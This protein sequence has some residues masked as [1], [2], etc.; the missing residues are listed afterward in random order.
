MKL[1]IFADAWGPK[2]GGINAFNYDFIKA[3]GKL[4][5]YEI[6][7]IC[8]DATK[9]NVTEAK[10][11]N[12]DLISITKEDFNKFNFDFSNYSFENQ[13][14]WIGHDCV[15]GPHAIS[16]QKQYNIGE[17]VLFNH[18]D[19]E[20]T[21]P[22][23]DELPKVYEKIKKQ[24]EV[25]KEADYIFSIGPKLFD[26][27]QDKIIA[28]SYKAKLFVLLPGMVENILQ[29]EI[30]NK[31][32]ILGSGRIEKDNDRLKQI[33]TILYS[34]FEITKNS[35]LKQ[36]KITLFGAENDEE[37]IKKMKEIKEDLDKETNIHFMDFEI[38]KYELNREKYFQ[39]IKSKSL[40][41]MLS[42][43]EGFGLVGLEM[44]SLGIPLIIS[45]NTGLYQFLKNEGLAFFVHSVSIIA[46]INVKLK[47]YMIIY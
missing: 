20:E 25:F 10:E 29:R 1:V 5:R 15:T 37:S 8:V 16:C 41:L 46:K 31:F 14:Y 43:S 21:A 3:V 44:I 22:M 45:E 39:S 6:I 24:N 12:I 34:A 26:S 23:K 32:S 19:Y 36:T 27:M 42:L 35:F 17:I 33:L 18:M 9:T 11:F 2:F 4:N 28:N 30:S 7:C 38:L 47:N 40:G 13:T